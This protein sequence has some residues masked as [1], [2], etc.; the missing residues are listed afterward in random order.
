MGCCAVYEG[1]LRLYNWDVY[2]RV[3]VGFYAELPHMYSQGSVLGACSFGGTLK[4]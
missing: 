2:D 1:L 4:V 3:Y